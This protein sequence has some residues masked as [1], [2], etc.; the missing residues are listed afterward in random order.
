MSRFTNVTGI[1]G[2]TLT[3]EKYTVASGT[4]ASIKPGMLVVVTSNAAA[5]AANGAASTADI[6]GIAANTSSETATAAGDVLLYRAPAIK[7]KAVA[8]TPGNLSS[9]VLLTRCSLDVSGESHTVD[10][11]DT[12]NGFIKIMAYDN[13]TDGNLDVE[14]YTT[15]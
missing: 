15:F 8:T 3:P 5:E 4:D 7:A 12:T 6:L 1:N 9:S 2:E 10:E 13:T 11:N 14:I